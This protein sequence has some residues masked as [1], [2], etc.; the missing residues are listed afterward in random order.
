MKGYSFLLRIYPNL[1]T[2]SQSCKKR[3]TRE[4]NLEKLLV[5]WAV[6]K[7][8]LGRQIQI[9]T[10]PDLLHTRAFDYQLLFWQEYQ[11]SMVSFLWGVLVYK[12]LR[13]LQALNNSSIGCP[14]L[15]LICFNIDLTLDRLKKIQLSNSVHTSS[16]KKSY[17]S[18]T[19][20][21]SSS[22]MLE[23][24]PQSAS[25]SSFK[26]LSQ[27]YMSLDSKLSRNYL[28]YFLVIIKEH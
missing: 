4:L 6:G 24:C 5:K 22:C 11:P 3:F 21:I 9:C 10:D 1:Q 2:I 17:N 8:Y 18:R 26:L 7:V 28:L 16:W 25:P 27:S 13:L 20:C 15:I 23:Q 12:L 19:L 14:Q